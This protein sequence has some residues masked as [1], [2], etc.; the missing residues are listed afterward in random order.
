MKVLWVTNLPAPY[1]RSMF[2][3]LAMEVDL[4]VHYLDKG[5]H[6][7]TWTLDAMPGVRETV[8]RTRLVRKSDT[9]RTLYVLTQSPFSA[10]RDTDVLVLGSWESPAYLQY[11]VA[12]KASR[13]A[14]VLF[15]ESTLTS[16]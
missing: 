13:K 2:K 8:V 5:M 9:D 11:L 3:E 4:D 14:T 7:R 10:V 16:N 15:Y 6:D 12:A 1:R